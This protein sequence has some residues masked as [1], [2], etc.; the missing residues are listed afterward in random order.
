MNEE[1]P[2]V[3]RRALV[4]RSAT[5]R[6]RMLEQFDASG[7]SRRVFCGQH[8]LNLTTFHGWLHKRGTGPTPGFAEVQMPAQAAIEVLL[9]NGARV[10]IHHHGKREDLVALVRGV[11]GYTGGA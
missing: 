10:G 9:P 3:G 2:T 1:Q 4:R 8:G 11:A 7:L 6:A 5:D